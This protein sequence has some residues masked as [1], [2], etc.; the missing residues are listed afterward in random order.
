MLD[1]NKVV[2]LDLTIA[3]PRASHALYKKEHSKC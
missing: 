1:K 2:F 3:Y